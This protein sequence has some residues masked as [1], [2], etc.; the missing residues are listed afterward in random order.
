M[1]PKHFAISLLSL[2]AG[3]GLGYALARR[4]RVQAKASIDDED[5]LA[6]LQRLSTVGQM[7]S[8][9]VHEVRTPLATVVLTAEHAQRVL[10][11]GG[12]PREQLATVAREADRAVEILS[13]ILD[14][15][16][17]TPLALKPAPLAAL[18]KTALDPIWIRF[19]ERGVD[20]WLEIPEDIVV[21]ASARHLHQVITILLMNSLDAMPFGGRLELKATQADGRAKLTLA[22]NG[23]GIDPKKL[24]GL[25]E[26]FA[27]GRAEQG[28]TGLG[29]NVARWIMNKHGG[30]VAIASEGA[31]KGTTVVLTLP[32]A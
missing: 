9:V 13:D 6:W 17:P 27:T 19:D 24:K 3:A 22:D 28:G 26:P 30:D 18:V 11:K 5:R 2:A 20:L 16:K 32:T 10:D 21:L 12:D 4:S 23:V 31:G 15:A 8:G 14:F 7:M 1:E 29:L 25:F